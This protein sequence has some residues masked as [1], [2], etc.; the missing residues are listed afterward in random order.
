MPAIASAD[1]IAEVEGAVRGGSP[2]CRVEM[3]RQITG[4]FLSG[5]DRLDE[6]QVGIFD[7]VLVRLIEG[8]ETRGSLGDFAAKFKSAGSISTAAGAKP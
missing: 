2:T 4:L 8:V 3:L 6:H 5:A 7:Q 1:F